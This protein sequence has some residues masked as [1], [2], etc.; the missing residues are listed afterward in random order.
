VTGHVR[1]PGRKHDHACRSPRSGLEVK[2][3]HVESAHVEP[4]VRLIVNG[5]LS[6][7]AYRLDHSLQT[8]FSELGRRQNASAPS[9]WRDSIARR[10]ISMAAA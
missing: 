5:Q 7:K 8:H 4:P 9:R 3:A 6:N 1:R 2:S 10:V